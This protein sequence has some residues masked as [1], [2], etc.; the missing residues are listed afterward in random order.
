MDVQLQQNSLSEITEMGCDYPECGNTCGQ[1]IERNDA[2]NFESV[3][4]IAGGI[5]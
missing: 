5:E 1:R 3:F 4:P 2:A